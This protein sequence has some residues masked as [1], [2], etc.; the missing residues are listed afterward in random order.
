MSF[1]KRIL[2]IAFNALAVSNLPGTAVAAQQP[3]AIFHA[4][5]QIYTEV[6]QIVCQLAGQGYSHIQISPAQESRE[7]DDW[8]KRYQPVNYRAVKGLGT[9]GDLKQLADKAHG[10]HV[11]VIA[12]VVFNHMANL[13]G[14]EE[15]ED[16]SKFPGLSK[17]NFQTPGQRPCK[18]TGN[19]G[20]GDG[21]RN[22]ELN[23]W[24]GGLPD[25]KSTGG[26]RL[27]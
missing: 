22:S 11:K 10:C 3:T 20:Y 9:V 23:C 13:S 24:L 18:D 17:D 25:L 7:G 21:N 2:I 19:N 27:T 15:F 26:S 6:E 8:W 1:R 5:N 12:D 4:F 16:L 14:G